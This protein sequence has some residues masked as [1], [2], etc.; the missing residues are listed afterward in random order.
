M[1]VNCIHRDMRGNCRHPV[2][3]RKGLRAIFGKRPACVFSPSS[4]MYPFTGDP[5][6]DIKMAALKCDLQT[7]SPRPDPPSFGSAVTKFTGHAV[8]LAT[9]QQEQIQDLQEK[10]DLLRQD[11]EALKAKVE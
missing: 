1:K 11:M 3:E 9:I 8:Q 10:V 7:E 6:Y 2:L 4:P 5:D